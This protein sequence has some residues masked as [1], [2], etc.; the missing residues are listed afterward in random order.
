MS[1]ATIPLMVDPTLRVLISSEQIQLRIKE[2]GDQISKDYPDGQ[3][4]LICI[5]KGACFFM[6]DL[7]RALS[8]ARGRDAGVSQ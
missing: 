5:L 2:L 7:A 8:R 1:C 6:T 4:H 3:L